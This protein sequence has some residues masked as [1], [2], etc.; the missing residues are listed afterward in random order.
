MVCSNCQNEP[1]TPPHRKYCAGCARRASALWKRRQRCAWKALGQKYWLDNWQHTSDE[2]RRAYFRQYMRKY[3]QK[4][5]RERPGKKKASPRRWF[6][7][8]V[9]SNHHRGH[10]QLT[11]IGGKV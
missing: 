4:R 8:T 7:T 6:G 9:A 2:S 11:T 5:R 3:R 1:V 10:G